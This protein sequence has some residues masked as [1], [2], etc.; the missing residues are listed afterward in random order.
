[1]KKFIHTIA[2]SLFLVSFFFGVSTVH[3]STLSSE[4]I[5]AVLGLLQAFNADVTLMSKVEASLSGATMQP[6]QTDSP[7]L[8][9]TSTLRF[10]SADFT[11]GGEVSKLQ[12]FLGGT[13]NG[14]FG[15]ATQQLVKDWQSAHGVVSSGTSDTTGYGSVGVKTRV[16]MACHQLS[17]SLPITP[18]FSSQTPVSPPTATSFG[19]EQIYS[20]HEPTPSFVPAVQPVPPVMP[21]SQLVSSAPAATNSKVTA[22][23]D[24]IVSSVSSPQTTVTGR[25]EGTAYVTLTLMKSGQKVYDSGLL[26]TQGGVW[27]ATIPASVLTQ[28]MYAIN[29]FDGSS[30]RVIAR[31]GMTIAVN[32]SQ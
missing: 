23:I 8:T 30:T 9:L 20:V 4:Q 25:A 11:T 31:G 15:P 1:M 6:S 13:V 16:A 14:H 28:G 3:A 17:T 26:S 5:Q 22:A 18:T 27:S 21:A 10:N 7:C 24:K 32:S 29:V 19:T 2:G 12:Q